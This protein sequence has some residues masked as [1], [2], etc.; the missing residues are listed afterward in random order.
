MIEL[1]VCQMFYQKSEQVYHSLFVWCTVHPS[2]KVISI[3]KTSLT[4]GET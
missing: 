4:K 2:V 3:Y 1:L